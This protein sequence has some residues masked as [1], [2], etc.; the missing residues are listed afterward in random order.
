[1]QDDD[2]DAS[3]RFFLNLPE[4]D[5]AYL[6]VDVTDREILKIRMEHSDAEE[7]WRI[8][9]LHGDEIIG[10]AVLIQPQYGWKRHTGAVR[11]IIAHSFQ[12]KG[13]GKL[14]LAELLQEATRR[15]VEKLIGT[16]TAE[17]AAARRIIE[18]LGFREELVRHAQQRS[19][20]GE[21]HD[22]ILMTVSL[23]EAWSRMEDLMHGMDGVG[24][25]HHPR[26]KG[27]TS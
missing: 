13:L 1:M 26:K 6:R 9:A 11:C 14:M 2:L 23:T 4:E 27:S 17:Q 8:V 12:G 24:R 25:E 18:Q 5:R 16:V 21:L 10:D 15:G 20:D 19:L 7:R 3:H 22:L